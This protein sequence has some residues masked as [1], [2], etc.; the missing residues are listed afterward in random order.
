MKSNNPDL[1]FAGHEDKQT[2]PMLLLEG[3]G[4]ADAELGFTRDGKV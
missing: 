3:S 4:P 2:S 1:D